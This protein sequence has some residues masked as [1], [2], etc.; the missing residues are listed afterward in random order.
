MREEIVAKVELDVA[1][2][3][4]QSLPHR[5][6]QGAGREADAEKDDGVATQLLRRHAPVEV[7]HGEPQHLDE[8]DDVRDRH[9]REPPCEPAPVAREVGNEA[10]A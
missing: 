8:P 9:A 5:V 4:D 10:S 1:G 3:P 7:V 2:D 6:A